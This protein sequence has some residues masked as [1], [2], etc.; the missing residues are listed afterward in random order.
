M[1]KC[2]R[3]SSPQTP[4]GG[5]LLVTCKSS[6][7]FVNAIQIIHTCRVVTQKVIETC[8]RSQDQGI[9]TEGKICFHGL[10]EKR[11]SLHDKLPPSQKTKI[12]G[13]NQTHT[14]QS[15]SAFIY[16]FLFYFFS[17]L[18]PDVWTTERREIHTKRGI[19]AKTHS[20]W[21]FAHQPDNSVQGPERIPCLLPA[22]ECWV[23]A[24]LT[25]SK[26]TQGW[27]N[28]SKKPGKLSISANSTWVLCSTRVDW[29]CNIC[30]HL[31]SHF[32]VR[33]FHNLVSFNVQSQL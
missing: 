2:S 13:K 28:K 18:R 29:A 14:W 8:P 25:A 20:P 15:N 33:S 30:P 26:H 3:S 21:S 27:T 17:E 16:L 23:D 22:T 31:D 9:T 11:K 1:S 4:I 12:L 32:A 7:Q 19:T 6:L 5:F 10:F 24:K